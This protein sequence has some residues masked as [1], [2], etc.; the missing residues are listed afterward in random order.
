MYSGNYESKLPQEQSASK[1][2]ECLPIYFILVAS[3]TG[4]FVK[5]TINEEVMYKGIS[6]PRFDSDAVRIYDT[7]CISGKVT[8]QLN[9]H[10]EASYQGISL[11]DTFLV[12][13][14]EGLTDL[15]LRISDLLPMDEAWENRDMDM[16]MREYVKKY[17]RNVGVI[18][19][20][21]PYP[22]P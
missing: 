16:D 15:E 19:N 12:E 14:M 21:Y 1:G 13:K 2:I 3:H 17:Q 9:I 4:E 11:I 10:L 8:D 5:L 22:Y 7:L 18:R 20:P 6:K